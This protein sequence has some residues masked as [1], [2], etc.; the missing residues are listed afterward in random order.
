MVPR[1]GRTADDSRPRPREFDLKPVKDEPTPI[2]FFQKGV[3][4]AQE[5]GEEDVE[6]RT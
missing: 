4:Q 1:K 3:K 2:I 5:K 6:L